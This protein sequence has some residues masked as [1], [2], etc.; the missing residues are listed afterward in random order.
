MACGF[1]VNP[2]PLTPPYV[3]GPF[4]LVNAGT[5]S[6]F[7]QIDSNDFFG[8]GLFDDTTTASAAGSSFA[9]CGSPAPA[10]QITTRNRIVLA[11]PN[12]ASLVGVTIGLYTGRT[13][14]MFFSGG[15]GIPVQANQVVAEFLL[16]YTLQY[17]NSPVCDGWGPPTGEC[18]V[19]GSSVCYPLSQAILDLGARL[20]DLSLVHWT[21]AEIQRYLTEAL[22]TYNAL[23]QSYRNRST[24]TSA[25]AAAFYDMPTVIPSLRQYTVTDRDLVLDIQYALMEPPS[26]SVWTGTSMYNL[27]EVTGA[28][29]RRTDQFLRTTGAVVTR[30]VTSVTPD[31]NGRVTLPSN[32]I[33]VRRAAWI[34][35]DGT[36]IPLTL[37]SEWSLQKYKRTWQTARVPTEVWPTVYSVN[38]TPPLTMQLGP[39]PS[40]AGQ[41]ELLCVVLAPTFAPQTSATLLG[42]PDD[43]TWVIKW[44]ALADLFGM[45]GVAFDPARAKHCEDRWQQG[46]ELATN[47]SVLLDGFIAG[48]VTQ[49]NSLTDVDMYQ[50]SW[51]TTPG[52]PVR[53]LTTGQNIIGLCPTPDDNDGP[54]YVV[55]VDVIANMP[56]PV[57]PTDCVNLGIEDSVLDTIYDY[58]EYLAMVKEGAGQLG[59]SV[60]LLERFMTACGVT[61]KLDQAQFPGRGPVLQQTVQDVRVKP[62]LDDPEPTE[63]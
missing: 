41:L 4:S 40:A 16:D 51:E 45:Q 55:T 2:N 24:F 10:V 15:S 34:M 46:L 52:T 61:L 13:G 17:G 18:G 19:P 47:A 63:T 59:E 12:L 42:I 5:P 48:D 58:A 8:N 1:P 28:I 29:Q 56:V 53:L 14:Q 43:W 49:V 36:I 44:G 32:V 22:R 33:T 39:P 62:R 6:A 38:V 35:A 60:Q 7:V 30:A 20:S 26:S 31:S 23:T 57:A 25:L 21:S 50:R 3:F 27:S 11:I 54:G 9:T 37:D